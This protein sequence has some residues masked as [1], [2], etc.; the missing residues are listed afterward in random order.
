MTG[1]N[2]ISA[3]LAKKTVRGKKKDIVVFTFFLFLSFIF[4]YLN[5]LGKETEVGIKYPLTY[6]NIPRERE[7]IE[8]SP[9]RLNLYL[10]GT[11]YSILK[12]KLSGKKEP[13]IIDISKVSY[14]RVPGTEQKYYIITSGLTKSINVQLRSDCEI[15]YI[16]PDTIFFTLGRIVSKQKTLSLDKKIVNGPGG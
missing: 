1:K 3:G 11:G 16:K 4:W 6:S 15:S 5:Y 2:D 8:D 14:K 10:K 12:L 7:I 9:E 13:V